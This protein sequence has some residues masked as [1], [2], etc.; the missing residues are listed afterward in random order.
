MQLQR[1][2]GVAALVA[3]TMVAPVSAQEPAQSSENLA[4]DPAVQDLPSV[5]AIQ[6]MLTQVDALIAK[7]DMQISAMDDRILATDDNQERMRLE[8]IVFKWTG[9]LD[10]LEEQRKLL[11]E[12]LATSEVLQD[13]MAQDDEDTP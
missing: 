5:A 3:L 7:Q 4:A 9:V 12:L 6:E 13:E 10:A 8:E 2:L 11:T 1:D